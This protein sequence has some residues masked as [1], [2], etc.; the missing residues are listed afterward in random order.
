MSDCLAGAPSP[1]D[2]TPKIDNPENI[3]SS[4]ARYEAKSHESNFLVRNPQSE[5]G[6]YDWTG[7]DRRRIDPHSRYPCVGFRNAEKLA[8][9]V[10]RLI[11]VK[12][13]E[14]TRDAIQIESYD[15]LTAENSGI[16]VLVTPEAI[17][18]RLPTVE[19]TKG[20]HGPALSTCL[21]QRVDAEGLKD[22]HLGQLLHTAQQV[23][24]GM[25]RPCR[26]CKQVLP[27]EERVRYNVCY[28][29]GARHLSIVS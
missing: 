11:P 25:F 5:Y 20:C 18:I 8:L 7:D 12:G 4:N 6:T 3:S 29:C 9:R 19:W 13:V 10:L 16:I 1:D 24:T 14:R 27:P 26:Y 21:W 22:K 23:R 2:A 28:R 17:E 15:D